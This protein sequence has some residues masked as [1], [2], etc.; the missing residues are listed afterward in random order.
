VG[1]ADEPTL[2]PNPSNGNTSIYKYHQVP[3]GG[4]HSTLPSFYPTG[5]WQKETFVEIRHHVMSRL[6][7]NVLSSDVV[8]ETWIGHVTSFRS[9]GC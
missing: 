9:V 6:V 3:L 8:Y 5:R 4:T 1:E 2:R 7:E